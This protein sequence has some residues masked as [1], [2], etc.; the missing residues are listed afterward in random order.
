MDLLLLNFWIH[1]LVT[2]A[3]G[4]SDHTGKV[5]EIS[6]ITLPLEPTSQSVES[7]LDLLLSVFNNTQPQTN[8]D[9]VGLQWNVMP[10]NPNYCN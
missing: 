10:L 4:L 7:P 9:N 2:L 1:M 5:S 3:H 8:R 6:V